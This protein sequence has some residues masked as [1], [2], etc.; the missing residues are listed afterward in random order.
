MLV[1]FHLGFT[2]VGSAEKPFGL[3]CR[4]LHSMPGWKTTDPGR[5]Q[6]LQ[7]VVEDEDS[8]VAAGQSGT[9]PSHC[10]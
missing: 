2:P 5:R 6:Y 3:K 1:F 9:A 7:A 10:G 8:C 4:G